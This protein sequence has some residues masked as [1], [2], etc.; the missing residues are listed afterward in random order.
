MSFLLVTDLF[1]VSYVVA[2]SYTQGPSFQIL[3]GFEVKCSHSFY[4]LQIINVMNLFF[5]C[6]ILY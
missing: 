6:S 2:L 3:F 1:Y 5:F 4:P